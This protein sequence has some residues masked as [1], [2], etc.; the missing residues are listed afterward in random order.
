MGTVIRLRSR[1]LLRRNSIITSHHYRTCFIG[2]LVVVGIF[3]GLPSSVYAQT[4]CTLAYDKQASPTTVDAGGIVDVMLRIQS[5][6]DCNAVNSPADVI[7]VID[8]SGSMSGQPMVDAQNAALTFIQRMNLTADQIGVVSFASAGDGRIDQALSQDTTLLGQKIRTL[9]A[10][11]MTDIAEGLELAKSELKSVRHRPGN[12]P[13]IVVLSDGSHNNGGDL[14]STADQVKQQGI[15]IITVGLSAVNEYQLRGIASSSADYYY[16]PSS[17]GL[18]AIY[19]SIAQTVRVSARNIVIT[20]TLSSH[21]TW[22]D[23]SFSGVVTSTVN[24]NVLGWQLAVAPTTPLVFY[25]QVA[26]TDQAGTWPTSD[27]TIAT[28]L[29]ADGNP[30]LITFPTTT[31]TV[32]SDCGD[33][34]VNTVQPTWACLG[35]SVPLSA[36]GAGFFQPLLRVG[37]QAATVEGFSEAV[38]TGNFNANLLGRGSY[39]VTVS[40]QCAP[41]T[42]SY[43]KSNAFTLYGTP[44]VLEVRP[45][46]GYLDTPIDVIICGTAALAPDTIAAIVVPTGT[47]STVVPLEDQF[48]QTNVPACIQ[49]TIP[50]G[51]ASWVGERAIVLSNSC[52]VNT[53]N[54]GT[55]HILPSALNDDLWSRT[56]ELW[57]D[58]SLLPF[59]SEDIKI[60][61]MVHRRGGKDPVPVKVTF[62]EN[63]PG[64]PQALL[65]GDGNIPLLSPGVAES[66]RITGTS[67]SGVG[68]LPSRGAGEY[69]LYAV[70]DPQNSVTEDIEDNN[71][72]SRTIQVAEPLSA[73]QDQV[74]PVVTDLTVAGGVPIIYTPQISLT[75]NSTDFAQPNVIPSGVHKMLFV[76]YIFNEAAGVWVPV[77]SSAWMTYT[78]QAT[79]NLVQQSGLRYIQAWVSDGVNLLSRF[80]YQQP[81]NYTRPC[82]VVTRDGRRV[83]RIPANAGDIV[84][85][86]VRSCSG[87]PDLYIW[88]P[89][90]APAYVSN[91]FNSDTEA[92]R[93]PA[94]LTDT[95]FY[96]I[97]VYGYSRAEYT[98]QFEVYP[99]DAPAT[100]TAAATTIVTEDVGKERRP[101]GRLAGVT[102]APPIIPGNPPVNTVPTAAP[103][104]TSQFS[105]YLPAIQR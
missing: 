4:G 65:I 47:T 82:E 12:A 24:S 59:A 85:V 46:A 50:A 21:V 99:P 105:L 94:N 75:V 104:T 80:P 69:T 15:R 39:N 1:S 83:Y 53:G 84:A 64:S 14:F 89:D 9:Y 28:Y 51:P 11:G 60:G 81:L 19:Q 30:Q 71:V 72:I 62:Y 52:G 76:E 57:L 37:T 55:I 7:L 61:L 40:N 96:Q 36:T 22:L 103:V 31:V 18:A 45:S 29:D 20:D 27:S 88:P 10:D 97:E 38:V 48:I 32:R 5:V 8:R 3:Y 79:W 66:V 98:I 70:I 92:I 54:A 2:F 101:A 74:A 90:E 78:P 49:G 100:V 63:A 44:D 102:T 42:R 73:D 13:V 68:W 6:G 87:D 25:Y 34:F 23:N 33:P 16:T 35:N 56:E 86:T 67:T 17:T 77:Q 93:I 43:T 91:R 26:M 58:P 41:Q 95:G